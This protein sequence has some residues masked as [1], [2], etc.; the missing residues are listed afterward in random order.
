MDRSDAAD[1]ISEALAGACAA[2][3]VALVFQ[4]SPAVQEISD[5]V[6]RLGWKPDDEE[7]PPILARLIVGAFSTIIFRS[8]FGLTRAGARKLL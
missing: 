3:A 6:P 4:K 7:N 5:R 2:V 1:L 8:V